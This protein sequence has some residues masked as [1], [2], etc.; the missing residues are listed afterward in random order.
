[1]KK[2]LYWI[3]KK[4]GFGYLKNLVPTKAYCSLLYE[5]SMGKKI[6]WGNPTTYNEKLQW[7]KLYERNPEHIKMV[8]KYEV[9]EYISKTIGD[10]YLIPLIGVWD[11]FDDIDINSLP[12]QFVLKCTHDSGGVV[13]CKDKNNLNWDAARKKILSSLNRNYYYYGREWP[14]KFVKPR[15]I[16]EK[17]MSD[18]SGNELNDYK[19]MCFNGVPRLIQ[20]HKNRYTD[21]S[22]NFYDTEWNLTPIVQGVN[23]SHS[24][25][26]KPVN[27]SKMLDLSKELSK[28]TIFSRIDF[29]DIDGKIYFGEITFC[30]TS[31]FEKI[32][33]KGYDELL[34][35][36]IKLP[37]IK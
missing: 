33:P 2:I 27:L 20:V 12:N 16:C 32:S 22:L 25:I 37:N 5:R 34:G 36:W 28:D 23:N 10:E 6:N 13:V 19:I 18:K 30:P 17:Y 35:S 29:Y 11:D 8:D 3:S 9:R 24:K 1:M 15:I 31:G 7:L 26:T 21:H 14:Y 4:T